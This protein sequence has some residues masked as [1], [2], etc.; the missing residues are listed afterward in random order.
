MKIFFITRTKNGEDLK[1]PVL[2][3]LI[4]EAESSGINESR[5]YIVSDFK[6]SNYSLDAHTKVQIIKDA[7]PIGPVSI[8]TAIKKIEDDIGKHDDKEEGL[9]F[10]VCSREVKLKKEDIIKLRKAIEEDKF[11]LVVGYKLEITNDEQLKKELEDYYNN[12]ALIAYQIPWNTCAIW[13]YRL[14]RQYVVKFDEI[15]KENPF[16]QV[17]VCIDN[18]C[19]QTKHEGMED[20]LAIAKAA[21]QKGKDRIY[22]KLFEKKINWNI[23][24]TKKR[25]HREKLARKDIVLR[26][27]MEVRGY[28]VKDLED[29]RKK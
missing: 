19:S 2:K 24:L 7:N 3:E 8:N 9:A 17:N 20:G 28:S 25:S 27:F 13:N 1:D 22:F 26:N 18:Y 29:A 5:I 16:N 21:S 14:F 4:K 15:T 12:K 10:L 6:E 11:M 23:D